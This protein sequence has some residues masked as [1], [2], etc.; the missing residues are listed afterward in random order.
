M[1]D[2]NINVEIL[3]DAY[4]DKFDVALLISAD[5]DLV[6]TVKAMRQLFPKKIVIAFPPK[7]YSVDLANAAHASFT[8][9]KRNPAKSLF[10]EEVTK[11]DGYILRCPSSWK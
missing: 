6:T 3:K 4:E 5:S 10:P 9:G 2:V 7:R 1:T 8:I 11:E